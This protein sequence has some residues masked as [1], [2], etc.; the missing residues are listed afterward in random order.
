MGQEIKTISY[1]YG[2]LPKEVYIQRYWINYMGKDILIIAW[3]IP[4]IKILWNYS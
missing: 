4:K 1:D 3:Y 2:W